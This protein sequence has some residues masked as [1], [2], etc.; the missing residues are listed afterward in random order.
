MFAGKPAFAAFAR[1]AALV[2]RLYAKLGVVAF[3]LQQGCGLYVAN[4][5]RKMGSVNELDV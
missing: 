5:W 2:I 4:V 1:R 3:V